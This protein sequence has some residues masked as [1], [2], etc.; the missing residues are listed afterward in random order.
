MKVE[1]G[2]PLMKNKHEEE[3][4]SNGRASTETAAHYPLDVILTCAV[5]IGCANRFG[6]SSILQSVTAEKE[7]GQGVDHWQPAK[8][9]FAPW[10]DR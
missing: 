6:F 3:A 10:P 7:M 4:E 5:R 9:Y 2:M 1:G 8:D